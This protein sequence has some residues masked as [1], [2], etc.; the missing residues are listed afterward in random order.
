MAAPDMATPRWPNWQLRHL[1]VCYRVEPK[2]LVLRLVHLLNSFTQPKRHVR[3]RPVRRHP[4]MVC[5]SDPYEEFTR[6]A[7][8]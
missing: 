3:K 5:P 7:R 4:R 8:G 2:H 6:Q 1:G